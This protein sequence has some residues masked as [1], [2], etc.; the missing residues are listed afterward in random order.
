MNGKIKIYDIIPD[1]DVL[2][3]LAPE[4]LAYSLL[5]VASENLQNGHVLRDVI[6]SIDPS[7]LSAGKRPYDREQEPQIHLAL[8]EAL[9]WLEINLFLLPA[10]GTNGV[11]GFRVIG[12]RGQKLL[13]KDHFDAFREAAA[14]PKSLL[15]PAIADRVWISL[16][17]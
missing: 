6:I 16:A 7:Q 11:N 9:Q 15:H 12:R 10:P 2:I 4:E 3:N 8:M 17:R 14:F 1:A 5:Q 13:D